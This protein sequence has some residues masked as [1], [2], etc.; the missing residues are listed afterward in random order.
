VGYLSECMFELL[1]RLGP[2]LLRLTTLFAR[3]VA[4][5]LRL[6]SVGHGGQGTPT[7]RRPLA[8]GLA[9]QNTHRLAEHV[10]V[11]RL[12]EV[13]VEAGLLKLLLRHGEGGPT[14]TRED[15]RPNSA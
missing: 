7:R 11:H 5:P 9:C 10:R 13:G 4:G 1:L 14:W 3:G 2:H 8:R 12:G 6:A 15:T